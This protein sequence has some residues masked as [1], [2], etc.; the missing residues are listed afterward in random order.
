MRVDHP[1]QQRPTGAVDDDRRGSVR[2]GGGDRRPGRSA[3]ENRRD[4]FIVDDDVYVVERDVLDAVDEPD[5]RE[6]MAHR[7][8]LPWRRLWLDG[9]R[10]RPLLAATR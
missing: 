8:S 5:V 6:D 2:H 9:G 3:R 4:P 7:H 10:L 1:R